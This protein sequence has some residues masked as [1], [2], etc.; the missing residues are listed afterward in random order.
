MRLTALFLSTLLIL[1]VPAT[2][3]E[4]VKRLANAMQMDEVVTILRDEGLANS[5]DLAAE[6]LDGGGTSYFRSQVDQIYAADRMYEALSTSLE[7][8]LSESQLEQ[9]ALFFESDVGQRIISLENSARRAYSDEAVEE[10]AR[11]NYEAIDRSSSFFLLVDEYIRANDLVD[12]NVSGSLSADFSFF[13]GLADGQNV[14][15]DDRALLSELLSQKELTEEETTIWLYSFLLLAY[16]PLNDAEM[17]ENIAFSRTETGR[18]LNAALFEGFDQ[19]YDGISYDLGL[20]IAQAL[21]AS[22]L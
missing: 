5:A 11:S 21:S 18:A 16:Q 10:L 8:T 20:A 19:L 14:S 22:D 1:A 15:T 7:Q 3:A 9:A 13:R 12:Q 4:A 6:M 17:R 2:A